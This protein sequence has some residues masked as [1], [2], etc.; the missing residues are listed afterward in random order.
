MGKMEAETRPRLF[1]R[2]IERVA[3][4]VRPRKRHR[5]CSRPCRER[6]PVSSSA[7]YRFDPNTAAMAEQEEEFSSIPL[8]DRFAHKVRS[9][10]L[11]PDG[12]ARRAD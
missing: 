9:P 10:C 8:P 2:L 6:Y 4:L 3:Q 5:P 11:S 12:P 1:R 7:L